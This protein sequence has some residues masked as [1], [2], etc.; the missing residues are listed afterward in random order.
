MADAPRAAMAVPLPRFQRYAEEAD[1][2][3]R[4]PRPAAGAAGA[5]VEAWGWK[6]DVLKGLFTEIHHLSVR[7]LSA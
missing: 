2:I 6:N 4:S 3:G 1:G 7:V 5:L